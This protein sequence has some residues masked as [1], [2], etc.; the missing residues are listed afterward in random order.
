MLTQLEVDAAAT[1]QLANRIA[2]HPP[3]E[4]RVLAEGTGI[5]PEVLR[6]LAD[7]MELDARKTECEGEEPIDSLETESP[8]TW[9]MGDRQGD[10]LLSPVTAPVGG[11][12][13][14]RDGGTHAVSGA[15]GPLPLL[16]QTRGY[17]QGGTRMPP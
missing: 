8:Q 3:M 13:A 1:V 14:S 10:V 2:L 12:V 15:E 17:K 16:L 7:D 6:H 11:V 4:D 5:H 9:G